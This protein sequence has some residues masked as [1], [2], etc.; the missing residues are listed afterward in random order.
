METREVPLGRVIGYGYQTLNDE[1]SNIGKVP[2]LGW[3]EV[4]LGDHDWFPGVDLRDKLALT[5]VLGMVLG[6]RSQLSEGEKL[7]DT[8]DLLDG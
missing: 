7:L 8:S 3:D 2:F 1:G 6:R 4:Q 5:D